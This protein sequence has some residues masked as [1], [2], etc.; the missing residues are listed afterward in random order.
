MEG[1]DGEQREASSGR[2]PLPPPAAGAEEDSSEGD[3]ED[4]ADVSER[5]QASA[6]SAGSRRDAS[7]RLSPRSARMSAAMM[8]GHAGRLSGGATARTAESEAFSP[9]FLSPR[10]WNEEDMLLPPSSE[11]P[12]RPVLT[13]RESQDKGCF[14]LFT[15]V[16]VLF[17]FQ[18]TAAIFGAN[19]QMPHEFALCRSRLQQVRPRSLPPSLL[20]NPPLSLT[21]S[22]SLSPLLPNMM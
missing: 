7:G 20:L 16:M 8:A 18:G 14:G 9:A 11:V 6:R 15:F 4:A 17:L 10:M 12:S 3:H 13:G 19:Y 5:S 21:P 2:P 1:A 22:F